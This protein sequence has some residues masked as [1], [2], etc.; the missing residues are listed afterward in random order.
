MLPLASA[1]AASDGKP[2][3][4]GMRPEHLTLG[5]PIEACVAVIEPMGGETQVIASLAARNSWAFPRADRGKARRK[6]R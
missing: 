5:G 1:P 2:A 4:Y 3:I 6:A